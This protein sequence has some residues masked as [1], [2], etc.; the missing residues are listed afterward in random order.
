M[1]VK[2]VY[3]AGKLNADAV[4]YLH[5]VHKMMNTAQLLKETGDYSVYVPCL[6]LLMGIMFGYD[7]YEDYFDNSQSWLKASEAVFLTS[8]WETS[9]GTIKE[10]ELALENGIPVFDH[11]DEMWSHFKGIPGGAIMVMDFDADGNVTRVVKERNLTG[12]F[13]YTTP[14]NKKESFLYEVR[15]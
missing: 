14:D 5:N 8:G 12:K 15:N 13:S 7:K 10:V 3:V 6:E 9:K 11:L 4:G 2:R 1:G